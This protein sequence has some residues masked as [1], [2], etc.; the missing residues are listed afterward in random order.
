VY[1]PPIEYDEINA[2]LKTERI[3]FITGTKEYGKT[4]TAVR[5]LYEYFKED[6]YHPRWVNPKGSDLEK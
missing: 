3:V 2:T 4:F 1:V 6:G 5:L